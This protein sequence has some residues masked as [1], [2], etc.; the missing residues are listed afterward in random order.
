MKHI[1]HIICSLVI[2]F[3]I[4]VFAQSGDLDFTLQSNSIEMDGDSN[5]IA[6]IMTKLGNQFVWKQ[7]NGENEFNTTYNIAYKIE[8]W[9]QSSSTGTIEYT[10]EA[11]GFESTLTITGDTNG[12]LATLSST[13]SNGQIETLSFNISLITYN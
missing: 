6:S 2:M 11:N 8:N 5:P 10:L 13:E 4:S 12:I 9:E 7:Q 1:K 3:S